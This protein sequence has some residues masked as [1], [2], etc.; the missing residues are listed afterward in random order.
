MSGDTT[1]S[2]SIFRVLAEILSEPVVS[3]LLVVTILLIVTANRSCF[4]VCRLFLCR[5]CRGERV[6]LSDFKNIFVLYTYPHEISRSTNEPA[7]SNCGQTFPKYNRFLSL[8]NSK[9][10]VVPQ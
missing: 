5:D 7:G 3:E 10:N 6:A 4:Y 9:T 1:K 2:F 8:S